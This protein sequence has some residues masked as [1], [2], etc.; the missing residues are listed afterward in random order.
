[1]LRDL[2]ESGEV[3]RDGT[4]RRHFLLVPPSMR[5]PREAAAWS[6]GLSSEKYDP[7]VRP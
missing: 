3:E 2:V 5:S 7:A 1:M 6:H 4:R